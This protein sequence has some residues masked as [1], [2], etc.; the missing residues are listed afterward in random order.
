[1]LILPTQPPI[2]QDIAS[3]PANANDGAIAV[4]LTS[5]PELFLFDGTNWNVAYISDSRF[6]ENPTGYQKGDFIDNGFVTIGDVAPGDPNFT[7]TH[8]KGITGATYHVKGT[9]RHLGA[10]PWRDNTITWCVYDQQENSFKLC[11][12][13]IYGEVQ[14]LQFVWEMTKM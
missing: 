4:V 13:E 10:T 14:N 7:V 8:N 6:I 3:L 12:Q 9:I 2:Y 5:P 11:L 1:M